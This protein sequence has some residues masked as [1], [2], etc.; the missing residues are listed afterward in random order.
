MDPKVN[1][2]SLKGNT[3]YAFENTSSKICINCKGENLNCIM[4]PGRY[5]FYKVIKVNV[6]HRRMTMNAP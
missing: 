1:S 4:K 2:E 3:I 5:H 6:I